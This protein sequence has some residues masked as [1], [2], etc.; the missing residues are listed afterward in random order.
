MP[1]AGGRVRGTR[2]NHNCRKLPMIRSVREALQLCRVAKSGLTRWGR[3]LNGQ[4]DIAS[5]QQ[6]K[7]RLTRVP[8]TSPAINSAEHHLEPNS[9]TAKQPNTQ[10][11]NQRLLMDNTEEFKNYWETN[12]FLQSEE[13]DR[14]HHRQN[15]SLRLFEIHMLLMVSFSGVVGGAW[16]RRFPATTIRVRRTAQRLRRR[17]RT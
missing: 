14:Y 13:F 6:Q 11:E 1:R 8:G 3:G 10:T 9:R 15:L 16:M 4:D 12:M 17:L 2:N 5:S 7:H